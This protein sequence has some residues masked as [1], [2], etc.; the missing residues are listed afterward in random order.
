MR[1]IFVRNVVNF[2]VNFC[3]KCGEMWWIFF[4]R[5]HLFHRISYINLP[6]KSMRWIFVRNAV[7]FAVNFCKKCGEMRWNI[8]FHRIHRN[9]RISYKNSSH[10]PNFLQ[11]CTQ[12]PR[13]GQ[14]RTPPPGWIKILSVVPIL[15]L[16]ISQL[17]KCC[18]LFSSSSL[19]GDILIYDYDQ[20]P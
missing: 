9:H 1:W 10:S 16:S 11:K 4:H 14:W 8:C 6:Q 12:K 13:P 20:A 18:N 2:A 15:A 7:K 17:P 3:K 5:I 19:V